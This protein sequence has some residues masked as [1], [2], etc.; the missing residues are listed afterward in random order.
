[1]LPTLKKSNKNNNTALAKT[2][3]SW[4]ISGLFLFYSKFQILNSKFQIPNYNETNFIIELEFGISKNWNLFSAYL[5]NKAP[6][7]ERTNI[8]PYNTKIASVKIPRNL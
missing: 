7:I 6:N 3:K 5:P 2:K 8:N 1:M 4:E